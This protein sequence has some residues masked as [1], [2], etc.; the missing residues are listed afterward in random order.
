MSEANDWNKNVIEEFRANSGK[1][2]GPF[3]GAPLLLLHTRGAKSGEPRVNP[4][5]YQA[6]GDRLI[7]FASYGGAPKNPAWFHNLFSGGP[8]SVEVGTETFDVTAR[9][10]EGAE[11]EK[12]WSKQKQDYPG[13]AG[14]EQK[15]TRQ[16]PVVVLER[17]G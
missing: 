11:R 4:M 8:A 15:T 7:V 12:Y 16:I 13:F 17:A 5:M 3:A 14:Y 10:T 2:G 1:V 9:T 6:D